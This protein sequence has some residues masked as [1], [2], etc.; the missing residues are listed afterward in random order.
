MRA[1]GGH[2][3]AGV[4]G[5]TLGVA[6]LGSL[7]G[8]QDGGARTEPTDPAA[9]PDQRAADPVAPA[10]TRPGLRPAPDGGRQEGTGGAGSGGEGARP[11][12]LRID[13]RSAERL[14]R[15]RELAPVASIFTSERYRAARVRALLERAAGLSGPPVGRGSGGGG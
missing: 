11:S 6:L 15:R 3:A 9:R 2:R 7:A 5:V 1:R 13:G 14:R 10:A 4:L 8:G 12:A